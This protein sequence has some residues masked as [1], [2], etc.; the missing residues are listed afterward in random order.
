MKAFEEMWEIECQTS[1]G[2]RL[3]TPKSFAEQSWKAALERILKEMNND[4]CK[5]NMELEDWIKEEIGN[6]QS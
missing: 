3:D 6:D 5:R 2:T 4:P 1:I